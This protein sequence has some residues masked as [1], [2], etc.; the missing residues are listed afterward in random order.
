VRNRQIAVLTVLFLLVAAAAEAQFGRLGDALRR[1]KKVADAFAPFTV[2]EEVTIGKEVASRMI[3]YFKPW[4]NEKAA[5]Y[6]RR[7]GELV[8][9]QSERQDVK[10]YFEV[11]D[12]DDVNAFAAPGGYIF[13]TRGLLETINTEAELA[14]VLGHE[15]GHVAGRHVCKQ[16]ETNK[17]MQAAVSE[18]RNFTP[19]S[20]Y[21]TQVAGEMAKTLIDRGLSISDENDADRRGITYA[22]AAGYPAD[23]LKIALEAL[24]KLS[25]PANE[26]RAWLERTHPPLADRIKHATSVVAEK[27][28]QSDGRPVLADRYKE[29]I[30]LK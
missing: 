22:Y 2:E 16:L 25:D 15:V 6:V 9:M 26:K 17:Q 20:A 8:S 21:V 18:A 19:G 24:Q 14:G 11:L 12:T 7:V 29:A 1:G 27:K 23:G 3:G 30:W 28:L 10:Y 5:A 4:D 13:V